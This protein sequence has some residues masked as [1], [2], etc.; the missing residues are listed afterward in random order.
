MEFNLVGDENAEYTAKVAEHVDKKMREVKKIN[1]MSTLD[2]AVVA[3]VNIAD[4]YFRSVDAAENLRMQL[5]DYFDELSNLK[6]EVA[7][8][9]R[10]NAKL[11]KTAK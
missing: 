2:S 4:D 1:G 5:K 9:R 10:E 6:D 3:A 8:L 11:Q 7:H